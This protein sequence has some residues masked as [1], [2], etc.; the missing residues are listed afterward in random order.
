HSFRPALKRLV[1][2][3]Q[4]YFAQAVVR[5]WQ[6][7]LQCKTVVPVR[8]IGPDEPCEVLPRRWPGL[9][10]VL[11]CSSCG[12]ASFTCTGIVSL[13]DAAALDFMAHH[14]RW[15]IEPERLVDYEGQPA[16]RIRL[17]DIA[18]TARFTLFVHV[19]SWQVLAAFHT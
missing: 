3:M 8:I 13:W 4:P 12:N 10:L 7:C 9:S 5:G 15:V 6:P 16:M 14:P 19:Q 11:A 1:Q 17:A 18:S 2:V